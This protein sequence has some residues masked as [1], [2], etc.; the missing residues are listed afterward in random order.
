MSCVALLCLF[1]AA[2]GSVLLCACLGCGALVAL[3][4]RRAPPFGLRAAALRAGPAVP[5]TARTARGPVTVVTV[6]GSG[7]VPDRVVVGLVAALLNGVLQARG[8]TSGVD[9][10]HLLGSLLCCV[11]LCCVVLCCVVLCCVVLVLRR[12]VLCSALLCCAA[13]CCAVLCC[14]E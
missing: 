14:A 5:S 4:L 2:A 12:A 11:V 7:S 13:L 8:H 3:P 9:L 1:V 6:T 10:L